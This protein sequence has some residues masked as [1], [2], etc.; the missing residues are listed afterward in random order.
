MPVHHHSRNVKASPE[1]EA[2][3]VTNATVAC[4]GGGALGHPMVYLRI[5]PSREIICPYCSRRYILAEGAT[6]ASGH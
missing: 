6:P 3:T 4:D 5:G 2:F 1:D